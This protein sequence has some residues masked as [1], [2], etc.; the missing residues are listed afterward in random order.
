MANTES[1]HPTFAS[2]AIPSD[3]KNGVF[4]NNPIID[5]LVSC[6]IAT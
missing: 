5:N 4:L 2:D 1:M 3:V 6:M